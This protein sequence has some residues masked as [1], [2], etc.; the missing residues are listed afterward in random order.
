VILSHDLLSWEIEM[1]AI[2]FIRPNEAESARLF[3]KKISEYTMSFCPEQRPEGEDLKLE[4]APR[5]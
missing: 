2:L 5:K 1:V 3:V 4:I